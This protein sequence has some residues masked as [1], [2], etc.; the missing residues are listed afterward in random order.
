MKKNSQKGQECLQNVVENVSMDK[1]STKMNEVDEVGVR[2][3]L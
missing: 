2:L 3:Q 1:T